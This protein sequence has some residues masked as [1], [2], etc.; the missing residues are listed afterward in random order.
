[1]TIPGIDFSL[2]N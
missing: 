1:V 2:C